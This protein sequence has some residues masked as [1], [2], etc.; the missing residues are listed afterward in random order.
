M[1][2]RHWVSLVILGICL[3]VLWL[4]RNVLLVALMAIILV[5]VLNRMVRS[6]QRHLPDRRLAVLVLVASVFLGLSVFG[7]LI[8][9]P[10]A[11]QVQDLI[12]VIPSIIISLDGWLAALDGWVPGGGEDGT[13]PG[14][15]T[16]LNQLNSLSFEL[17]FGQ[18]FR[19]FSN[20][21][22][23]ALNLLI[24]TVLVIMILLNPAAYRRLF[25]SIFPMAAR[26]Q[27]SHVLDNC[28]ETISSWFTGVFFS[29]TVI[30]L[31]S[32]TGLSLLGV[33]LALANGLLAGLL[34]FIPNLGL[35]ISVI[36]PVAIALLESPWKAIAVVVLYVVIQQVESRLLTPLVVPRRVSLLPAVALVAQVVFAAFFGAMGLLLALP[37]TLIIQQWLNEFWVEGF[38]EQH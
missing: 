29:M 20:T 19:L 33:P 34:A 31:M 12:N 25:L 2:F 8:I 23:V 13:L 35:V 38:L 30:A 7:L 18:F 5:V 15:I 36:F 9:P 21:L 22:S 6:L 14:L 4:I 16:L 3:Y 32:L 24:A 26:R 27:V 28:E 11:D 1:K 37:L 10:F 17:I